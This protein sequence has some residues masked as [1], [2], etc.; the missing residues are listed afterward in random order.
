MTALWKVLEQR[1]R[2]LSID[3]LVRLQK[4]RTTR[5]EN[6]KEIPHTAQSHPPLPR[7][8]YEMCK[9]RVPLPCEKIETNF[10]C[11]VYHNLQ[12]S[13]PLSACKLPQ[14]GRFFHEKRVD[15]AGLFWLNNGKRKL[16]TSFFITW[17][18]RQSWGC[19]VG[20]Y[21]LTIYHW[22]VFASR[23][24]LRPYG[25]RRDKALACYAVTGH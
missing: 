17:P 25:L 7:D 10:S 8:G 5:N 16:A 3:F 14:A 20:L 4:T 6:F 2:S 22:S 12:K 13:T 11:D 23:F 15:R 19:R 1:H 21:L 24:R 9:H 18:A